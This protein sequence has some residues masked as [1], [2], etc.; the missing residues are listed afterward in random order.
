MKPVEGN[1]QL[2]RRIKGRSGRMYPAGTPVT[3]FVWPRRRKVEIRGPGGTLIRVF[4][5]SKFGRYVRALPER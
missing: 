2:R 5:L 3:A 4:G 1:L